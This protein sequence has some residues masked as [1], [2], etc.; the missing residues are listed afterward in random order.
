LIDAKQEIIDRLM[1]N[2]TKNQ[3]DTINPR[4]INSI[5]NTLSK[6]QFVRN[7]NITKKE[8]KIIIDEISAELVRKETKESSA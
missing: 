5:V 3:V 1:K 7:N 8:L 2:I 4:D 6:N